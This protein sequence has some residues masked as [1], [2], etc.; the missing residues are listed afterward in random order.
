MSAAVN[1]V[2]ARPETTTAAENK[3]L[4]KCK[5][6]LDTAG[7]KSRAATAQQLEAVAKAEELRKQLRDSDD[8]SPDLKECCG[9]VVD[10]YD[11][12][13]SSHECSLSPFGYKC[14]RATP[15]SFRA[16]HPE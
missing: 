12:V 10:F 9:N 5:N 2:L 6:S 7:K 4:D 13:V 16:A 11:V 8:T 1:N 3:L 15:T 14:V